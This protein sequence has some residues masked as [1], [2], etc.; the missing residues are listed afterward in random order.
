MVN[1]MKEIL[2]KLVTLL[3]YALLI[4]LE[5][6][7]FP[8]R[9]IGKHLNNRV[10]E[11]GINEAR[12]VEINGD[13][14]W[15]SIYS[16]N[17]DNPVLLYLHGGPGSATS[18]YDY[19]VT[20]K[21]ADDY[22]VVV[23]DQREAGK[24]FKKEDVNNPLTYDMFLKDGLEMTN[25]LREYLHKDRISLVGHSWGTFLGSALVLN[26]PE[27]YDAYIGTGQV[28]DMK[29]N[30]SELVKEAKVWSQGDEEGMAIA[31]KLNPD[32]FDM[33]YILLRNKIMDRYKK[34]YLSKGT[35]Y[36]M[37]VSIFFNPYYSIKD[38]IN[39]LAVDMTPYIKFMQSE[40]FYK[41]CLNGKYDYQVPVFYILG[42][43][44]YQTNVNLAKAYFEKINAP[45]KKCYIMKDMTHG[46]LFSRS[47]EFA[48]LVK[49]IKNQY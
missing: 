35:D 14:Q 38:L 24:S 16:K 17:K 21:W 32:D 25:F 22:T 13:K 40:E 34:G 30:E 49:E 37:N 33:N 8:I 39:Y 27:L 19:V 20:R 46:L 48:G 41:F 11:N 29:A 7:L 44:D 4:V 23:W 26:Y 28:V 18:P 10:P 43:E 42:D 15:I 3:S 2:K 12:F 1:S 6:V 36:N 31:N 9:L 5:V 45:L 47:E